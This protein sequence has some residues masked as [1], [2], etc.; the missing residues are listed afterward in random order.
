MQKRIV[1]VLIVLIALTAG[2]FALDQNEAAARAH[3]FAFTANASTT[4]VILSAWDASLF[5]GIEGTELSGDEMV[6]VEGSQLPQDS[7]GKDNFWL[8]ENYG[9]NSEPFEWE[10]LLLAL[11]VA[12]IPLGFANIPRAVQLVVASYSALRI[13]HTCTTYRSK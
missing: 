10:V 2:A 8:Q 7:F 11:D 13:L 4:T 6:M 1:I 12:T 5:A 3:S 9:D